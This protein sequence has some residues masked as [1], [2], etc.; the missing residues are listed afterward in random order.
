MKNLIDQIISDNKHGSTV[1]FKQAVQYFLTIDEERFLLDIK[2]ESKKLA[3]HFY[4][5]GLFQKL[6]AELQKIQSTKKLKSYLWRIQ[7][8]LYK[9]QDMINAMAVKAIYTNCTLLTISHSSLVREAVTAI[10]KSGTL[11]KIFCLR[12]A[13]ANEGEILVKE[14]IDR[15][16]NAFLI[17]D[18]EHHGLIDET[19]LLIM[20]CD[21]LSTTFFINKKGSK[22]LVEWT[23]KNNIP[24]WIVGDL[25]RFIPV[26]QAR[27]SKDSLFEQIPYSDNMKILCEK[28]LITQQEILDELM[29]IKARDEKGKN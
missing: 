24:V 21:L 6:N 28:G 26:F 9:N 16:I 15:G 17:E 25:L 22:N 13:P 18:E 3:D 8:H 5:M 10:N 4:A 20:G 14:L 23:E 1:L 2:R 19:E 12:S 11:Q 29:A 27:I 7:T